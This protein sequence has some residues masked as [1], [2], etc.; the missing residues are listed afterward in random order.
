M[1]LAGG[2]L[3]HIRPPDCHRAHHDLVGLKPSGNQARDSE[4][5]KAKEV[6]F[7]WRQII[8]EHKVGV[9]AKVV[10]ENE[11]LCL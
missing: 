5:Q 2:T 4:K 3:H 9:N 6:G 11:E 10:V 8:P 1:G 7:A